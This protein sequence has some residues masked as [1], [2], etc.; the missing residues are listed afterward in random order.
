MGDEARL[1][2]EKM[3]YPDGLAR[4]MPEPLEKRSH[5]REMINYEYS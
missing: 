4:I 3:L 2:T 1:T 5:I